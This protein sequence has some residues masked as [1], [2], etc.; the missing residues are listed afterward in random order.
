MSFSA[1]GLPKIVHMRLD[2]ELRCPNVSVERSMKWKSGIAEITKP[3][4]RITMRNAVSRYSESQNASVHGCGEH[5]KAQRTSQYSS[6]SAPPS[7]LLIKKE[8]ATTHVWASLSRDTISLT[9]CGGL[10]LF[11]RPNAPLTRPDR[12][13]DWSQHAEI[14]LLCA[15]K[16]TVGFRIAVGRPK[17][18]M[19]FAVLFF[20][21]T[22]VSS[23][24]TKTSPKRQNVWT[25]VSKKN[26]GCRNM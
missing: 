7:P 12:S 11:K 4:Y 1:L 18:P 25:S 10:L 23:L 16:M 8:R 21:Y 3:T 9:I 26:E 24:F 13:Q 5:I 19:V 14:W 20:F 15:W 6:S 2:G 17:S 22:T